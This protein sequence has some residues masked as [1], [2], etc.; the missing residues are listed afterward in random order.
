MIQVAMIEVEVS[1]ENDLWAAL[2][3]AES[4]ARKAIEQARKTAAKRLHKDAEVSIMLVD[5]ATI[6]GLNAQWRKV[7]KATNVLSF[8][9]SA[10][11]K[12]A[13]TPLLGDIVVAFETVQREALEEQ[14]SVPDH[15]SHL[16]VHG[17][18]HLLGYDHENEADADLM[19]A[20]EIKILAALGIANPYAD[21]ELVL[22]N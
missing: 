16:I 5:D 11:E 22:K 19:E 12:L 4:L 13:K 1:I 10:P 7:D 18:L 15:F 6:K 2:S 14:K 20:L 9:A 21:A 8:P 17:F 3:D